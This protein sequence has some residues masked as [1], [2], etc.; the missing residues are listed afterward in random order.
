M[1]TD[2]ERLRRPVVAIGPHRLF[3]YGPLTPCGSLLL[4]GTLRQDGSL[5]VIGTLRVHGYARRHL[6][7]HIPRLRSSTTAPYWLTATLCRHD[8]FSCDGYARGRRWTA[9]TPSRS[10]LPPAALDSRFTHTTRL[11]Q[12]D[13]AITCPGCSLTTAPSPVMARSSDTILSGTPTRSRS[14]M[15]ASD[16]ARSQSTVLSSLMTRSTS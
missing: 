13:D 9:T 3:L 15:L 1:G 12:H 2:T 11:L 5:V 6:C 10:Y 16:T 7:S 4:Y 8:A 14:T